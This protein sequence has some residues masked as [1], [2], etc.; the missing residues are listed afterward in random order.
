MQRYAD[1]R[2]VGDW[3]RALRETVLADWF[4]G[5]CDSSAAEKALS[6]RPKGTFLVR[7]SASH[8]GQFT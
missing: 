1:A 7:M 6:K 4:F 8:P 3:L 2:I 5:D